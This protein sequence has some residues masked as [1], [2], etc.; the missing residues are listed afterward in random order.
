MSAATLES[1]EAIPRL[2]VSGMTFRSWT[3]AALWACVA[4]YCLWAFPSQRDVASKIVAGS[5]ALFAIQAAVSFALGVR[6]TADSI[7]LPRTQS[8]YMPLLVFGRTWIHITEMYDMAYWG[9]VVM[10]E[11]ICLRA[12][13]G[14]YSAVFDSKKRRR[15]FLD[16]V[17]RT[18][19]DVEIYGSESEQKSFYTKIK[20]NYLG[21]RPI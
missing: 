21:C 15:A 2:R 19:P 9:R 3:P 5:L 13:D 17:R 7:I 12:E 10:F 1:V 14:E 11:K 8:S 4:A 6:L 18:H 20:K 16:E